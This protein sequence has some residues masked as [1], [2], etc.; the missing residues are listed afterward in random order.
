M[1]KNF[2][3]F[4]KESFGNR[5]KGPGNDDLLS[6]P[7]RKQVINRSN[8]TMDLLRIGK[9]IQNIPQISRYQLKQLEES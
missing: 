6:T 1:I 7:P 3:D 2:D 4:V 8:Q 5:G 9:Q